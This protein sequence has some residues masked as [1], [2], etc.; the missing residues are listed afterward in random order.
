MTSELIRRLEALERRMNAEQPSGTLPPGTSL[1][2]I[3]V[4]GGLPP[5]E[6]LYGNAGEHEWLREPGEDLDLF[7]DR[8]AAAAR[9][10]KEPLLVIGSLPRSD[11][12]NE[13]ALR[14]YE[15]WLLT[16]DGVPPM[17]SP[18]GSFS[19]VQRAIDR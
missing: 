1:M 19:A 7:A 6:P 9:E 11:A 3:V 4:H 12:Q 13:A 5:G 17:E 2:T 10:L 14:A 8:C 18:R 16:D 15:K